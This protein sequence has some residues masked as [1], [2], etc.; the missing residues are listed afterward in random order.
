MASKKP[1]VSSAAPPPAALLSQLWTNYRAETGVR[2]QLVD[3]YMVFLL[4]TGILQFVHVVLVGTFPYNAFISGFASTVGAFVF[5]AAL[6]V[7]TNPKNRQGRDFSPERAF[8]DFIFCN[9]V[10]FLAV[11]NFIG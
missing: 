11:T 5:A 10:L 6:R 2:L 7:Q 3:A 8:A 1:A 4:L 9:L